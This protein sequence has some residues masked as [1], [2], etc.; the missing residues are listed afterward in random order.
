MKA[1]NI[2][3]VDN[4][5]SFT[6]N[7]VDELRR[8]QA[9]V[10]VWRNDIS[11]HEALA[12]AVSLPSPNLI[13]LSPGPCRPSDAGCC[14]E[15]IKLAAGR[16][17]IFGVC[18]GHQ[19]I[20]EAFGGTVERASETLHGK[21][22]MIEHQGRGLFDGLPS[23]LRVGR[24]HSLVAGKV[25][26]VLRVTAQTQRH[27]MAIEHRTLPIAGVQF[28]PESILTPEGGLLLDN[29]M[30]WVRAQSAS[31]DLPTSR[32]ALPSLL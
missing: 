28:H 4:F 12:K 16:I 27:V 24:Y 20:V 5:D 18:L 9:N 2:L 14:I 23:P 7:L 15:L 31:K 30:D 21:T 29:L 25:P 1:V 3:M 17:P 26:E 8:R 6:F 10:Q 19:A 13:V 32:E 11:A 22:S